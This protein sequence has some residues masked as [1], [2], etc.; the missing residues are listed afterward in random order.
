MYY[1]DNPKLC[2]ARL[3]AHRLFDSIWKGRNNYKR[4][5][6]DCYKSLSKYLKIP[7]EKCHIRFFTIEQCEKTKEFAL[8]FL[9]GKKYEKSI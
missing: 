8:S 6:I 2:K 5:R 7:S 9:E 1:S 3:E 4:S